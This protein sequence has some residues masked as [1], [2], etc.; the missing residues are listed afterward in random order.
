M[1]LADEIRQEI[2]D[3]N[4]MIEKYRN[5]AQE[6]ELAVKALKKVLKE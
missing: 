5:K 4:A 3:L 2:A 1:S 6:L